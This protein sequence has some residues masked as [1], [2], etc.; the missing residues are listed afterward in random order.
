MNDKTKRNQDESRP[1]EVEIRDSSDPLTPP[2]IAATQGGA[3]TPLD[4]FWIEAVRNSAKGG[5]DKLEEAAKQLIT[6]TSLSQTIY[7]TA[8]SI[9]EVKKGTANLPPQLYWGFIVVLVIPL[10]AWIASLI[11]AIRVFKPEIYNLNLNSPSQAE[12]FMNRVTEYKDKQLQWSYRLLILGFGLLVITVVLYFVFLPG[13][14]A[15]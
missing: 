5:P 8:I 2:M 1:D 4:R 6:I 13:T 15:K 11:F 3:Q 10:L 14:E 9:S 7:F 12:E